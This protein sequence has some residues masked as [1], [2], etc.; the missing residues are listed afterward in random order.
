MNEYQ[1]EGL[2]NYTVQNEGCEPT[3]LKIEHSTLEREKG[4][5]EI[6]FSYSFNDIQKNQS[7]EIVVYSKNQS[8]TLLIENKTNG[9]L[10]SDTNYFFTSDKNRSINFPI[11]NI[12]FEIFEN[13]SVSKK[14]SSVEEVNI[15]ND[16]YYLTEPVSKSKNYTI[17]NIFSIPEAD[18]VI[19]KTNESFIKNGGYLEISSEHE[20]NTNF[21][22][23]GELNFSDNSVNRMINI[24]SDFQHQVKNITFE[25]EMGNWQS[26][27]LFLFENDSYEKKETVVNNKK[28]QLNL[29]SLNE[30]LI[31]SYT[32]KSPK[33]I[34]I[35]GGGGGFIGF[36]EEQ[37]EIIIEKE[38]VKEIDSINFSIQAKLITEGEKLSV[39]ITSEA[40]ECWVQI[41]NQDFKRAILQEQDFVFHKLS[42]KPGKY[43]LNV[44]CVL[45]N[46]IKEVQEQFEI[47][48]EEKGP[49]ITAMS[50]SN[51]NEL[52]GLVVFLLL[53]SSLVLIKKLKKSNS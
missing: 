33:P 53:I 41:E 45:N 14:C 37:P 47:K 17:K 12:T 25:E 30:S 22:N 32:E 2:L 43:F 44:K 52:L 24:S 49:K 15:K 19:F 23:L 51:G 39:F 35:G 38:P 26:Y 46:E 11:C 10:S 18:V 1:E 13:E 8:K 42:V 34:A 16:G 36:E 50:V 40:D 31:L 3:D 28:I 27:S 4:I 29:P 6:N 5:H 7:V 48:K 20:I 9:I 21:L